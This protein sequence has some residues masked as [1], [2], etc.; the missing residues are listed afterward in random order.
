MGGGGPREA[1]GPIFR[2]IHSLEYWPSVWKPGEV[3]GGD[4][5][6]WE[7]ATPNPSL[8]SMCWGRGPN[9]PQPFPPGSRLCRV[10]PL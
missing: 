6:G 2:S 10:S 8:R 1:G 5:Q 3:G 4:T 7:E 9:R